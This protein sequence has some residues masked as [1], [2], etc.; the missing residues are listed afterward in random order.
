M[1]RSF[2]FKKARQSSTTK[3]TKEAEPPGARGRNRWQERHGRRQRLRE[4]ER[5][6]PEM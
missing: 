5:V 3:K 2:Y 4:R 1:V 6:M